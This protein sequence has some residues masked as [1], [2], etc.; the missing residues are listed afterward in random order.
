M[1]KIILAILAICL[2]VEA[3]DKA[4]ASITKE[5]ILL[6]QDFAPTVYKTV[7]KVPKEKKIATAVAFL[8]DK[9][10]YRVD[11][12]KL[13]IEAVATTGRRTARGSEEGTN[14]GIFPSDF[15]YYNAGLQA[16]YPLLDDKEKRE[17][18]KK[19]INFKMEIIDDVKKYFEAENEEHATATILEVVELK[20]IRA[21]ARST[22]GI[23]A[24]DERIVLMEKLAELKAKQ[25]TAR[26]EK[27]ALL[28]KLLSYLEEREHADFMEILQ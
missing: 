14:T 4:P 3:N 25:A 20:Q 17:I 8:M 26:T 6:L 24:L 9:M 7:Q 21:K 10:V 23:I 27:S 16:T 15:N 13:K 18:Q 19:K 1:R 22:E 5:D 12:N 28:E 2:H 11:Y